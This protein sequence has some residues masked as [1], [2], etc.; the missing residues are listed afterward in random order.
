MEFVHRPVLLAP[1]VDALLAVR[2]GGV[3]AAGQA[4][5]DP[6]ANGVYVDGTFG[7]GGHSRLLLERLG[8]DARLVVFD[9]DPVAIE[10]A[11][12]LAAED[13]RV[14]VVHEGFAGMARELDERGIAGVDGVMLD[15]GISS[16]Q[17]DDAQRGF[18]FMR[19]GPLDMRMD[20][21]RGQ[22]AAEWLAQ[23]SVDDMREVI[24]GY[25]EERFAFQIAKAI[26]ARRATRPLLTTLE[27]AELV[28]GVVRT[29][30]KGQHPATRTF[31]ALRIYLNRELEELESAL[32][33][34]LTLLKP[35]GRL[36]VI[37]FHSLEDRMVKQCIAAAAKPSE[38]YARLPLRESEMPRPV[39]RKLARVLPDEQE[40][41]ANPRARSAVLRVAER[42]D[43][44]LGEGQ[45]A[46]FVRGLPLGEK[47]RAPAAR[48][49]PGGRTARRS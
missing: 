44:P 47:G 38:A 41:A 14:Q 39:L 9:K 36:A 26:A 12:T 13:A 11:R 17:I 42:T 46:A 30:E 5:A 34:A 48:R 19:D 33:A 6:R 35:G 22:T 8:P 16:P 18:S 32:Q 3:A 40:V 43:T 45:A 15:L 25:G 28:A 4:G 2:P 27:L 1:T 7:R 20:T 10:A 29:R 24:A 21:S 49:H 23:A 37:S 31:Q